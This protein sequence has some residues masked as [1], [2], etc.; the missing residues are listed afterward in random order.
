MEWINYH[1]LLYF[2]TVSREG[3]LARA[4][5]ELRLAQSTVSK[6]IH[7]LETMLG[8]KLLSKSGRR[9]VLTE[10][11]RVVFR[12]ADEIFG[13]G[14]EM[15]DTLKDRPIGKPLRVTVGVAD[16]V[17]KLIAEHVLAPA[18]K[19]TGRVRLICR[20]DKPDRLLANL[21]LHE[22]DVILTDAPA[23]PQT[24]I[25]AFSHLLGSS[26]I[27]FFGRPELASKYKRNFPISLNGAPVLLP[28]E[29]TMMRRSLEQWFESRDI[30]PDIVGEFEDSALLT[31]FGLRGAGLFP[32]AS[33]IS[34]ELHA[35]Y[36]VRPI[37]TVSG[38]QERLY[39]VTVERRIKHPTVSAIC[40]AAETWF[41][42]P[43]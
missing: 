2:W 24:N 13:L 42:S 26:E 20:E 32:A 14:R 15:V 18:L 31:V 36:R 43:W 7:Q 39:A 38:V 9:L 40:E 8:H 3:S 33:V 30:R 4:S 41:N 28:T 25:R 6:Q 23:S 27:A 12:Y 17:P 11:G 21:A 22:L 35:Q 29:N 34:R 1:H 10:S 5:A 19:M 16:I 37:G